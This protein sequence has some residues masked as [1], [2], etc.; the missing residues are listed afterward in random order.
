MSAQISRRQLL[1]TLTGVGGALVAAP[2]IAA[3]Q[4]KVVEVTRVVEKEKLVEQTVVVEKEKV[5]E[6]TVVVEKK[7][8]E[9]IPEIRFLTRVGALGMFMKEYSRLYVEKNPTEVKVKVEEGNWEDIST[10]LMTSAVAGTI[11]DIFWQPYFYLPYNIC[12][13]IMADL[14]D[15]AEASG[16]DMS[17][18]YPWALECEKLDGKLYGIP[19][20]VMP[21]WNEMIYNQDLLEEAGVTPQPWPNMQTW[22]EFIQN[23]MTIKEKTGNWGVCMN[24][25][26]WGQEMIHRNYGQ[27]MVEFMGK[28]AKWLDPKVQAA[29]KMSYDMVNT[30]KVEP[31]TAQVEGDRNK[32]FLAGKV[33]Y[34]INCAA[35]IVCGWAE[36]ISGKF[37]YGYTTIPQGGGNWGTASWADSINVSAISKH[38]DI[39][40]KI[41]AEVGSVEASKWTSLAT[42]MTP[43]AC[44]AAW[45][46]PAVAAKYPLY[47]YEG[48][49]FKTNTPA[50]A[51]MPY[52]YNFN[53]FNTVFGAEWIPMKNGEKPWDDAA[54]QAM[55]VKFNDTL[56]KPRAC[57]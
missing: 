14:T 43:G 8:D 45:T 44:P 19:L 11:Q 47:G 36:M 2:I 55:A 24:N 46:D 25:W 53:E 52:N 18:W 12:N 3:C 10:K 48:E 6:K 41:S 30:Y 42:G 1:R 4:P 54:I 29:A 16:L 9:N 40:F 50:P 20:G 21:G 34:M 23:C 13:G 27:T 39:C 38:P 51:A 35:D 5:V 56:A 15:A 7:S 26:W 57:S 22:E 49:W 17:I 33:G 37:R 32:M 31:G 28:E